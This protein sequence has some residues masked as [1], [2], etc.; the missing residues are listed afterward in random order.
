M[1]SKYVSLRNLLIT[2]LMACTISCSACKHESH[3][4]KAPQPVILVMLYEYNNDFFRKID[5][6]FESALPATLKNNYRIDIRYGSAESAIS[7]QRDVLDQ[8]MAEYLLP[9]KKPELAAVVITPA[10]TS[11]EITA[12][13]KQLKDNHVPVIDV[14]CKIDSESLKRAKTDCDA[15]IYT[16][17]EAGGV[18]AA[19]E[20]AKHLPH[21]GRILLLNGIMGNVNAIA[22]RTGFVQRLKEIEH[23]QS[24]HYVVTERTANWS[25][26]DAR[27]IVD[28]LLGMGQTFDAIFAANDEMALGAVEALRH[29]PDLAT[30]PIVIGFDA[31]KEAVTA[32]RKGQMVATIAQDPVGMGERAAIAVAKILRHEAV[33]KD[34]ML[35]PKVVNE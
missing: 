30:K 19:N 34:Q 23:K 26:S 7:Y 11:D 1:Q 17:N 29:A 25:R 9:D 21:G 35:L 2:L 31:I 20:L 16:Q 12:E 14:D 5:E 18:L 22:R 28:N 13:I 15:F 4:A 24:G 6:G 33:E 10:G 3:T 8:Y 27:S 32:I